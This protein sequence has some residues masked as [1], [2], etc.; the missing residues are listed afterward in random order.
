M[1]GGWVCFG[2]ADADYDGAEI[3]ESCATTP[4]IAQV[5][6]TCTKTKLDDVNDV[7]QPDFAVF[8]RCYSGPDI[9]A[10]P[11]CAN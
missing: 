8:Q 6:S 3:L 10:D 5:N 2:A 1:A 11:N 7:G 4:G 9:L